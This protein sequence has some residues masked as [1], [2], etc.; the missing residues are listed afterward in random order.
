MQAGDARPAPLLPPLVDSHV[1]LQDPHYAGRVDDLVA[2][3]A[4]AGVPWLV[5]NASRPGDWESVAGHARR[6]PGVVPCFG[7]HPWFAVEAAGDW[8]ERLAGMLGS[9]PSGVGEIGIDPLHDRGTADLQHEVFVRQLDLARA[10]ALPATIH[11]AGAWGRLLEILQR[12]PRP[13]R[14]LLH[15][16]GGPAELVKPLAAMGAWFSFGGACLGPNRLKTRRALP[17]IPADRML[18]ETDSPGGH[19]GGEATAGRH[20]EPA[21]LPDICREMARFLGRDEG[22]LRSRLWDNARQLFGG[23]VG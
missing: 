10:G 5:S 22:E 2:R 8:E 3:A 6:F 15:A 18:L 12:A 9:I 21:E 20:V 7:I 11:C 17:A 14:F 16:Y 13:G 19:Q 23:L 1:H 4:A